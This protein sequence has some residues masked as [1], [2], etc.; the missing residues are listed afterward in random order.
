MGLKAKNPSEGEDGLRQQSHHPQDSLKCQ[1]GWT[2]LQES[3]NREGERI[4][5]LTPMVIMVTK[6]QDGSP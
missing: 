3:F 6:L 4:N 1:W 2:I 5:G